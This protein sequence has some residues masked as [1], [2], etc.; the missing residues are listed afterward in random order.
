MKTSV[1]P[2]NHKKKPKKKKTQKTQKTKKTKPNGH[3][4]MLEIS[5]LGRWKQEDYWD[6]LVSVI[7]L[8][9]SRSTRNTVST[10]VDGILEDNT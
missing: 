7:E 6:S 1:P 4:S 8:V 10:Q 3:G 9:T 2:P 5:V